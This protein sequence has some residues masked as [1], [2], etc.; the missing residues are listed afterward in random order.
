MRFIIISLLLLSVQVTLF[1]AR[2]HRASD[3]ISSHS[4]L[5]DDA[6]LVAVVEF[7]EFG[8]FII[9]EE[10]LPLDMSK[11]RNKL[12]STSEGLYGLLSDERYEGSEDSYRPIFFAQIPYLVFLKSSSVL[13]T[14]SGK[15]ET[16]FKP[17]HG[18]HSLVPL[19]DLNRMLEFE[20]VRD[21][22]ARKWYSYAN[23]NDSY[24][25]TPNHYIETFLF[26]IMRANYGTIDGTVI[27]EAILGIRDLLRAEDAASRMKIL[28]NEELWA[29]PVFRI[30]FRS[31][32]SDVKIKDSF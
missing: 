8:G 25:Y 11:M 5:F 24:I 23:G 29:N 22:Y 16:L 10:V 14:R 17:V 2:D 26:S 3:P 6:D 13:N 27:K 12:K 7:E 19:I 31:V 32:L 21:Y 15:T 30:Y 9:K 18:R 20:S 4:V 1:S 28:S